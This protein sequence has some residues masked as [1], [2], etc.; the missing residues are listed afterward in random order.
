CHALDTHL[1]ASPD[2]PQGYLPP[3]GDKDFFKHKSILFLVGPWPSG[4][5]VSVDSCVR[6]PYFGST[7]N[8]GWSY[9]T[10]WASSTST[11]TILPETSD[12]ISLN[13]FMA[14]MIQTT[15]PLPISSPTFTK[16]GLSGPGER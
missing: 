10:G 3:I 6:R 5:L 2:D 7:K 14:S 9:S 13:S 4:F 16:A 12:S 1:P 8:N 15:L 11:L